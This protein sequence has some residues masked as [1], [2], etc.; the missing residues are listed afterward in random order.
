MTND[1]GIPHI[2][3]I[4]GTMSRTSRSLMALKHAMRAA[5]ANGAAIDLIDLREMDLPIFDPAKALSEYGSNVQ[6]LIDKARLA[7]G[8]IISTGAYHGTLAGITKNALDYFEFLSEDGYL[9]NKVVGLIATAG[10]DMA[11]VHAINAMVNAVHAL[12]GTTIP[13]LVSIP[14][15]KKAFNQD[16]NLLDDKWVSRLEILGRLVVETANKFKVIEKPIESNLT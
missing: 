10:G 4:G 1:I 14:R 13:L 2:V 5:E 7:D 16:G 11:G 9:T 8:F 6:L 15:A 12:R 3:G